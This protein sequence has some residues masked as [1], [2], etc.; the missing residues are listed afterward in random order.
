MRRQRT[1]G[2]AQH[3]HPCVSCTEPP[4]RDER[5]HEPPPEVDGM[6]P[7]SPSRM[8]EERLECAGY[9][10]RHPG[11]ISRLRAVGD[12]T[13]GTRMELW[14]LVSEDLSAAATI[15]FAHFGTCDSSHVAT[16]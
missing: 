5:K 15:G 10:A 9:V 12:G 13:R 4:P 6:A 7:D 1:A 3:R 2:Q 14:Q 8:L 16:I 11:R